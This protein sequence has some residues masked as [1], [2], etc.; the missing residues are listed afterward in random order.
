M[1]LTDVAGKRNLLHMSISTH[2]LMV[3]FVGNDLH[4]TDYKRID[5]WIERIYYYHVDLQKD[6]MFFIHEPDN[7]HAPEMIS[8][9]VQ[10]LMNMGKGIILRAPKKL[11]NEVPKLFE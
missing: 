11:D 10:N 3:R 2:Q 8:Y 7:I 6:V 9:L 1:V 5:E 4:E